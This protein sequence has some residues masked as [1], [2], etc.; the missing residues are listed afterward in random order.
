MP[1]KAKPNKPN[2]TLA[3]IQH[4][5]LNSYQV[6]VER[7]G[8]YEYGTLVIYGTGGEEGEETQEVTPILD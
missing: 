8:A 7:N 6:T 5:G 2:T 4:I 1:D 3:S